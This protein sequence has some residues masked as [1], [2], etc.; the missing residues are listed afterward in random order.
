MRPAHFVP[1]LLLPLLAPPAGAQSV[2]SAIEQLLAAPAAQRAVWGIHAVNLA[3]GR[4]IYQRNANVPLTPAS[5]TKL[6][7]TA[8]ALLRLGPDYRF[9]TRVL[10]ARMPDADGR[11]SGDLILAGGGDPTL[12]ARAIPYQKG[13]IQGDPLAPLAALADQVV[14]AG[15]RVVEGDIVGDDTRWPWTPFPDGWSVGDIPWE[16][17]APVSALT[18]NDN[19]LRLII[20]PP[21]QAGESVEVTLSPAV[22]HFTIHNTVRVAQGAERK[23]SVDRLPGSRVLMI[24]GSTPP[25]TG[26]ATE[27]IAVDD[28]ALFAAEALAHL[29]RERGI[30][31]QGAVRAAHRLPGRA[32]SPGSGFVLARR[33]SPPLMETLRVINKVSQN[34]HAEIVL[35]EVGLFRQGEGSA[36]AAQKEMTAFLSSLGVDKGEHSFE[37]ASG[38]SRRTLVTPAAITTL[39]RF[40]HGG[41]FGDLFA[42]T[43]PAG[44]EDGTLASRFRAVRNAGAIRAKTGSISHVSALSGYVVDGSV[45]RIAFSI[46][47][48]GFTAP[49]SE[50]RSILDKIA[51]VIQ[52]E[53]LR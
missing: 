43:L 47:V 44:G 10:A 52:Q 46:V 11:L 9:E 35:R 28:P 30:V 15:V 32:A 20:R 5:N 23:I 6:F 14:Q 3:T 33:Q 2:E 22:D 17:G 41:E 19:A 13:P 34:L 7:S 53:G 51:V 49:A 48:N 21:K 29:L 24:G 12:S 4:T 25:G 1:A 50:I 8:L 16:Y 27:I 36:T 37:D 18:V 45:R 38:L 40:L 42:A 26:A 39:L 31:I